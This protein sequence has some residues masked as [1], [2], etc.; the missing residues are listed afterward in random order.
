MFDKDFLNKNWSYMCSLTSDK[1]AE[2][3]GFFTKREH[4]S[5][6]IIFLLGHSC[7]T[8]LQEEHSLLICS[9]IV[10]QWL[11]RRNFLDVQP[12]F[13]FQNMT[14]KNSLKDNHKKL[15]TD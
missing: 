6:G 15:F 14:E 7:L 5:K 1:N 13:Y 9:Q 4:D 11:S 12:E 8:T 2:K 3:Y 10:L